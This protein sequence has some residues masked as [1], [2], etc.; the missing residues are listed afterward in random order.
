MIRRTKIIAT[1]GPASSSDTMLDALIAA[2][3]DIFRLNFSHGTHD[4]QAASFARIRAAA[5]RAGREV[6]ILQDLAG[7]KI[8]TGLLAGHTP[9][10]VKAGD[11]LRIATGDFVGEPGRV[12][13]TF[14][15][16]AKSVRAGDRLLLAD[17]L[18]ELRV[19]AT[20]GNEIE[21]TVVDGG[22]IGEHKGINA[23]GVP[24]PTSAITKKDIEDLEFG[25]SL[26]V[27]MV[28]V[29]FV[30]TAADLRRARHLMIGANAG[31]VPLVAK[32]ERPQALDALD[33]ILAACDA[34]MVARGDLGLEMPLE[35]VPRAQKDITRAA[36]R[37]GVP[38]VVA[39]QVLESM[40]VEARPTRAEVNDAANAVD[41]G[42]DAIMLAGETAAGAHPVKAVQTLD[43]IIRDAETTEI[44]LQ[45]PGE[46]YA[47]LQPRA[48]FS[49]VERTALAERPVDDHQ[50]ALCQAAVTL[51]EGGH[52]KAIVAVTQAG[53]T[54]RRLS[55]K[56]PCAPIVAIT[57][58]SETARRV[59]MYW[60]V[61]PL[62]LDIG[63]DVDSSGPLI[64]EE[65]LTRGLCHAGAA[66]VLVRIHDDIG[67]TDANY[68]KIR[69]L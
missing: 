51:A 5:K 47:R 33:E 38:V 35:R 6:A 24:L 18:I 58:R 44:R 14:A 42:V 37:R 22:E 69:R 63:D 21:T 62:L 57:S 8:R 67:R 41:D 17:G 4:S 9:F 30:Q 7:P 28:A 60:G 34:V 12:S 20:D 54:A 53:H 15:G 59:E 50:D 13:T 66:V 43:A 10:R 64:R 45:S 2:G 26:G 25:L 48:P 32:L 23:P 27:D 19:V 29:S 39:T 65:L 3:T 1:V 61:V 36:R 56:R 40:M 49:T 11:T 55:A 52:A 68:L 31:D 46:S 16:L